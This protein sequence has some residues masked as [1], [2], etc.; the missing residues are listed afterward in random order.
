MF[1]SDCPFNRRLDGGFTTSNRAS[2]LASE[3]RKQT[4]AF[5]LAVAVAKMMAIH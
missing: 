2:W 1:L 5:H 4:L 3:R